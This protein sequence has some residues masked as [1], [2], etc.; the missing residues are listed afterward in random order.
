MVMDV[1]TPGSGRNPEGWPMPRVLPTRNRVRPASA[2]PDG[3]GR[4]VASPELQG[5]IICKLKF[6]VQLNRDPR[7]EGKHTH[8]HI[9]TRKDSK[10]FSSTDLQ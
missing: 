4:G 5:N 7:E 6:Y 3:E 1:G 10:C 8:T 2:T 9:Y